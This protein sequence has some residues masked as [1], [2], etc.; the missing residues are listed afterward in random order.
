MSKSRST[1][2]PLDEILRRV[3]CIGP[4]PRLTEDEVMDMV[5]EEIRAGRV[6]KASA[7]RNRYEAGFAAQRRK[8]R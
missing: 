1:P 4:D 6:A 8:R 7:Q 3:R 5:V 2:Q